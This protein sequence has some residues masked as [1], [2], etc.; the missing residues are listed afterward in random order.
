MERR[1]CDKRVKEK[2]WGEKNGG[3]RSQ[4]G[5]NVRN[6][7]SRIRKSYRRT[8]KEETGEGPK[9]YPGGA[10]AVVSQDEGV[11]RTEDV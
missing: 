9:G 3:E 4:N 5:G 2:L 1:G 8:R 10:R 6:K 11:R 7:W